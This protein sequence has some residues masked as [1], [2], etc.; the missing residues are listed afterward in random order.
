MLPLD[1]CAK[2]EPDIKRM[3]K[4]NS[5]IADG[6]VIYVAKKDETGKTL[7]VIYVAY[8]SSTKVKLAAHWCKDTLIRYL[9]GK[10]LSVLGVDNTRLF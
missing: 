7:S 8:D 9:Q 6:R 10:D 3:T 2:Y 4:A 5:F 1:E